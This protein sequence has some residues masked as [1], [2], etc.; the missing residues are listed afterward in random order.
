MHENAGKVATSASL[1]EIQTAILKAANLGLVQSS[2]DLCLKFVACTFSG[3]L[4]VLLAVRV[5]DGTAS[6]TSNCEKMV[7]GSMLIKL[8]KETISS[9]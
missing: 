1:K 5:K 8:V 2:D 3:K 7:F 6:I 4:P 9:L